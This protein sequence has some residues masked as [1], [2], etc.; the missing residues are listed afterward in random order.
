[1]RIEIKQLQGIDKGMAI[2]ILVL[3]VGV[4]VSA[5]MFMD[6]SAKRKAITTLASQVASKK[7]Q[8]E[9]LPVSTEQAGSGDAALAERFNKVVV[10]PDAVS[11]ISEQIGRIAAENNCDEEL[12]IKPE[13]TPLT[14]TS[15][16]N[17]AKALTL[18]GVKQAVVI[19]VTFKADYADTARFLG[20]ISKLPQTLIV[21]TVTLHKSN[22]KLDTL[23][24]VQVYQKGV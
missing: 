14:E 2:A 18:L 3:V 15:P 11:A 23:V 19:T 8:V 12:S 21:R 24:A 20:A 1:M 16:G 22:L 5:W 17:D 4:A 9:Q 6:L 7:I 13:V 10:A